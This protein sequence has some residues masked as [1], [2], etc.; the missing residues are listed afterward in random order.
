MTRLGLHR[1]ALDAG[2]RL[3]GTACKIRLEKAHWTSLEYK[4]C[5]YGASTIALCFTARDL[6]RER[7]AA[8]TS[9]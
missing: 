4:A 9:R 8:A 3:L 2:S 7:L 1:P 5:A 6:T